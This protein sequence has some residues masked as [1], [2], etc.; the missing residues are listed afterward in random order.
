MEYFGNGETSDFDA[1]LTDE[2]TFIEEMQIF[3]SIS[4][5]PYHAVKKLSELFE[6]VGF[7]A[8]DETQN[9]RLKPNGKYYVVRDGS[10]IAAFTSPSKAAAKHGIR[11]VGAHTDSPCLK[12]NPN[13]FLEKSSY[14]CL[15]VEVYGSPLLRTWFDR[16]LSIAGQVYC[17][18]ESGTICTNLVDVE[19]PVAIIPSIAIHLERD[20]NT[21]QAIDPAKHLNPLFCVGHGKDAIRKFLLNMLEDNQSVDDPEQGHSVVSFDLSLYD[22]CPAQF[23]GVSVEFLASARIDNLV[24]CY[25]AARALTKAESDVMNVLVCNDHEEV[26]SVSDRGARGPF[27]T[28]I[29]ERTVGLDPKILR[30]SLMV[31]TDGAH[32]VHPNYPHKHEDSH[33]PILNNGI[34]VKHNVNQRYATSAQSAAE[35][36]DICDKIGIQTQEFVSRNDMPCGTTIGPLI[37]SELGVRTVDIGVPQ[38][39]M[40]SIR[41]TAGVFDIEDLHLVLIQHFLTPARQSSL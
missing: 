7:E 26:G 14:D 19:V 38:L 9:W 41:E 34:V 27:L 35:F 10:S 20:A 21:T 8:L 30:R 4:P 36:K 23:F 2:L 18:D 11:I 15:S 29:L 12:L 13:I 31:S 5:T 33:K 3:L 16:E 17:R 6:A 22:I 32:G 37:A 25:A 40:H 28:S 39:A 1:S 24:S